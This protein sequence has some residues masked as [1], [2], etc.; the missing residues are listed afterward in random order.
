MF[1]KRMGCGVFACC[2]AEG[3]GYS[4]TELLGY[5]LLS[6]LMLLL[7]LPA[8]AETCAAL[9]DW[10]RPEMRYFTVVHGAM[11]TSSWSP[12]NMLAPLRDSTPT[13]LSATLATRRS[14]PI[15][16]S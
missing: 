10:F 5:R 2:A 16:S 13:T 11:M 9:A 4:C 14:L 15:G 12:P 6:V 7:A 1:V 8:E 3:T